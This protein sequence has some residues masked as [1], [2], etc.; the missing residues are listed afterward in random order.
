[1]IRSR[2]YHPKS[3]GKC[4]VS[5]VLVRKKISFQIRKKKG[6]N[7]AKDLHVIQEA[8]NTVPKGLIGFQKPID[9]FVKRSAKSV[10]VRAKKASTRSNKDLIRQHKKK[11][12]NS[13]YKEGEKVFVRYPQTSHRSN[14]VPRKRY[15]LDGT[16]LK[17]NDLQ[18]RYF[19]EFCTP[20]RERLR[21]WFGVEDITSTTIEKEKSEQSSPN[22]T[23][24]NFKSDEITKQNF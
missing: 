6:F 22:R 14:R 3:Q 10:Q 11:T 8:M 7:W 13:V 23:T 20:H 18:C 19:V 12:H 2:L 17:R 4:E 16:I 24:K 21:Q 9:V 15:I 5:Q 1:M